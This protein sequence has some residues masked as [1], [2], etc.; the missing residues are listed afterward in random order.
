MTSMGHG[1]DDFIAGIWRKRKSAV[2]FI[3]WFYF[4]GLFL[5]GAANSFERLVAM[6][7]S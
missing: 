4:F 6:G 5:L 1:K 3:F 7:S 2:E